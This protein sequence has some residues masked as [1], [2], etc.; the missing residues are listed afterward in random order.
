MFD[1]ILTKVFGSRNERLIKAYRRRCVEI[2]RLEPA[3]KALTDAELQGKTQELR[4]RLA[5][6]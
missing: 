5:N 6:G 1:G 3:M 2:N 4:E